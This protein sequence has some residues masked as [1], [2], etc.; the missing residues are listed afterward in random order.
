MLISVILCTYNRA[1]LL[2]TALQTLC[3]Q[4]LDKREYEVIVVD[5]NSADETRQVAE[6]FCRDYANVRY[7]FETRQG[8]SHA[9]NRG[10][11]EARGEYVA[12][13][14]DDCKLPSQW[15]AVAKQVIEEISPGVLGGPYF[16][17]YNTPKPRW[18]K[19]SYGSRDLG[20][21]ARALTT[22]EFLVGGK[23]RKSVV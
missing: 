7:V 20:D 5:N 9:R 17:F 14:D 1:D 13:T 3:E 11:R 12:Y 6:A 16:A 23:D 2:A 19:D 15:L 8:L 4:S 18:F 10:W 21:Q 22:S